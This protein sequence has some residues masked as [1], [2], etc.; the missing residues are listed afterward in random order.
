M[1]KTTSR[2]F[3]NIV[4]ALGASALLITSVAASAVPTAM[5]ADQAASGTLA[6]ANASIDGTL[7]SLNQQASSLSGQIESVNGQIA[8]NESEQA[9]LVPILEQ[10]KALLRE[11]VRQSYI[12][13]E[14]SSVEVV[15][16]NKSFSGVVGQQH[17][18]DRVSEK[19][20]HA[21]QEV[22]EVQ[23]QIAGKISE[24]KKKRDGLTA[25]KGDLDQKITSVQAQEQAKAALAEATLGQEKLYQEMKNQQAAQTITTTVAKAPTGGS[26]YSA[27]GG[28]AAGLMGSI[29]YA[30]PGGNCVNEPGVNNPRNGNPI[31][32]PATSRTPRIG[33]TALWTYNHTGVVTGIWSNGD[34]EVRHQN[35]TGGQHR[36]PRSAFRGFR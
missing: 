33:A 15:A 17:Y 36:F 1:S 4:S 10:K 19:T 20:S 18:R 12:T 23:K 6:D 30:R 25:M 24:S 3:R 27:G 28:S 26:G 13:G 14:P 5:A 11:T 2:R 29:G 16:S 32:W 35:F 34:I 22:K 7:G 9:A 21:A 31:D 8:Q